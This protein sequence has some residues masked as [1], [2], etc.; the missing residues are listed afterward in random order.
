MREAL[1]A[2]A[3][4]AIKAIALLAA[5]CTSI[6]FVT[7]SAVAEESTT[8]D[9]APESSDL[10]PDIR[11][12]D[13]KLKLQKRDFVIV[14]I[15]LSN[16]TLD[17]GLV[18]GGA[19]FWPQ[20][21]QQKATQPASVT[22][23][24]AMYTSNDS[25]AYGVAQN[26]YWNEDKW[27]FEG[28]FGRAE[29]KLDL[30]VPGSDA[31]IDWR[32]EGN[33]LKAELLRQVSGDWYG[34]V[35]GRY[36]SMNQAFEIPVSS[37]EFVTS[38]SD[39]VGLGLKGQYDSRDMPFNS[40]SGS[41]F[42]LDALFHSKN[43]GSDD[44]YQAYNA[45]YRSYHRL[46]PEVVLAWEL[47]GCSISGNVPLWDSCRIGLRGFPA[48]EFLGKLTGS[49]QAEARWQF[50]RKWGAVA[51]AGAGYVE[52]SFNDSLESKRVPSYGLGAR[53]MVLSSRRINIRL[54]YARSRSND[55][56]YLSVGEAF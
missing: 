15:P 5:T 33:F 23:A 47:R 16:P 19:F 56:V 10:L 9:T 48:T 51:F 38:N 35:L 41:S 50:S 22:G 26:S 28:V 40:Y 45:T 3:A 6:L 30:R 27:R 2:G 31:R 7:S 11:E 8:G 13:T 4:H 53:F 24:A 49:G 44:T 52:D 20:T 12:D 25:N 34:G 14:P 43:V 32:I 36:L 18:V 29:L 42:E 46:H 39:A 37:S 54:D 55:G 21:E 1:E 17:T